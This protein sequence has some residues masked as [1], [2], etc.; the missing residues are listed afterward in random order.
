MTTASQRY[1][2]EE[3]AKREIGHTAFRR[4]VAPLLA[5][6]FLAL[7]LGLP[8][9]HHLPL[10]SGGAE[11]RSTAVLALYDAFRGVGAEMR[12]AWNAAPTVWNGCLAANAALLRRLRA[13]GDRLDDGFFLA[14]AL[15]G[16][17]QAAL[18]QAGA[19]NEKV[20]LGRQGWLFYEPDLAY[21]TGPDFLAE[22]GLRARERAAAGGERAQPDP[23]LAILHTALQLA[24]RDI[25]LVVV[26]APVKPTIHPERF[27]ED[28]P[29]EEPLQNPAFARFVAEIENPRL[30]FDGRFREW[31]RR[32]KSSA[33][34]R[35]RQAIAELRDGAELLITRPPRLFDP[36]PLLAGRKARSGEP[37]YLAADSHWTPAAME[38]VA[39]ELAAFLSREF[40]LPVLPSGARR[41]TTLSIEGRGD[42]AAMLKLPARFYPPENVRIRQ[43]LEGTGHWRPSLDADVLLL[44]DSFANIYSVAA[45]GWGEAAGLAEHLSLALGRPLDALTRNDAGAWAT[46]EM[47]AREM[48]RGR[49]R[50]RGK[51]VV[52]WQFAAR[53]LS[54]GDWRLF[55]FTLGEAP[56]ATFFCPPP[57]TAV[58]VRGV[59]RE[60]SPAPRP[61][62]VPYKD[63]IVAI[64]LVDLR[65]DDGRI[66]G[67]EA[68]A[69]AW[70]MRDQLWTPAARYRLGQ[71]VALTLRPWADVRAKLEAINRSE[72]GD[73]TLAFQEPCWAE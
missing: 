56:A 48:R 40:E 66:N 26:P 60:V 39:A 6:G 43:V 1:D 57:G 41:T 10:A 45:M 24:R 73:D 11:D 44:G 50:L 37:Q 16:P 27:V 19:G 30:F 3:Q 35:W 59:V 36:A 67:A 69:Y 32:A 8:L 23:V 51:R 25:R 2:R 17:V 29:G 12:A 52:I 53:E 65:T 18:C 9:A 28:V 68:V 20:F 5:F 62:S 70:S 7:I 4:G 34:P 31:E 47:L 61:G 71:E 49:D 38:A 55:D 33:D 54:S 64:H 58:A 15:R 21:V 42:L 63:H 14:R 72:L 46:R 13:F 22:R